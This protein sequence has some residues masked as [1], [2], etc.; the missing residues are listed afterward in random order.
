MR[1]SD[2]TIIA[3]VKEL[4]YHVMSF[5]KKRKIDKGGGVAIL[6]KKNIVVV[7]YQS[8][9]HIECTVKTNDG[10]KRFVNVYYPGYSQKHRYTVKHFT[11]EF[12]NYLDELTSK[13]GDIY[14]VGDFNIHIE[15][16]FANSPEPST[17]K[18]IRTL[19][20]FYQLIIYSNMSTFLLIEVV[21]PLT[22]LFPVNLVTSKI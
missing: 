16:L 8:F 15:R 20:T 13:P 7:N 10:L 21:V 22:W 11:S 12:S 4:G 6:F 18:A 9:E 3:E 5:R 14:I 2:G 19:T 1:K 17:I